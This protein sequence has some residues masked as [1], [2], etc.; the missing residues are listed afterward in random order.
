MCTFECF[1]QRLFGI[2]IS[3]FGTFLGKEQFNNLNWR[4]LQKVYDVQ[5][6]QPRA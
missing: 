3:R 5:F 4:E 2:V 1:F 6:C